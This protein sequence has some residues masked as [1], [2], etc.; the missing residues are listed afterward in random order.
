MKHKFIF[1]FI[2][3]LLFPVIVLG[4]PADP[5]DTK[6]VINGGK[7]I[8][9]RL[10]GDEFAHGHETIDGYTVVY[11]KH[12][13]LWCYA[14]LDDTGR[15]VPTDLI[16]GKDDPISNN[17]K[18]HLRFS[19]EFIKRIRTEMSHD[20]NRYNKKRNNAVEGKYNELAIFIDFPDQPHT[21]DTTDFKEMLF[22]ESTDDP[23]SFSDYYKE[24][25]NGK[26][27][28]KGDVTGWYTAKNN[29]AYYGEDEN[30][31]IDIYLTEL[32]REALKLAD[33]DIDFSKYDNNKS[34]YISVNIFHS[35]PGE[36][37][38]GTSEDE[39][40]SQSRGISPITLDGVEIDSFTIQPEIDHEVMSS[41]GVFCH[42]Y[43]HQLGLPDLYDYDYSSYG[44]GAFCLMAYGADNSFFGKRLDCPAHPCA[45]A[46]YQLG[47]IDLIDMTSSGNYSLEPV[48]QSQKSLIIK[49]SLPSNEFFLVENRQKIGFDRGLPG[50]EGG[51]LIWHVD[52]YEYDNDIDNFRLV[53][54]EQAQ[55]IQ[56]MDFPRSDVRASMGSDDDYFREGKE[57]RSDTSPDSKS[58][59]N[60][61]SGVSIIN[62]KKENST[63]NY[64]VYAT[65]RNFEIINKWSYETPDHLY[66]SPRIGPDGTI[67]FND[68]DFLYVLSPDGKLKGKFNEWPNFTFGPDGSVYI[69]A[70]DGFVYAYN[71]NGTLKWSVNTHGRV[72]TTIIGPDGSI[73]LNTK[74]IL[75]AIN[76]DGGIKW[77][78]DHSYAAFSQIVIGKQGTIYCKVGTAFI[79][80]F[81]SL[82]G[83]MKWNKA[84]EGTNL[85]LADKTGDDDILYLGNDTGLFFA[86]QPDGTLK[87]QMRL[88]DSIETN[89]VVGDDG[90]IYFVIKRWGIYAFNSTSSLKW[91]FTF[92]QMWHFPS[93]PV[94]GPDGNIYVSKSSGHIFVFN[95]DGTWKI[96]YG[97]IGDILTSPAIAPDMTIYA[98]C[99][100]GSLYAMKENDKIELV[101]NKI[102]DKYIFNN[103][104][105]LKL[106]LDLYTPDK[107]YTADFYFILQNNNSDEVLYAMNWET[108]PSPMLKGIPFGKNLS[109]Y[110]LPLINITIPNNNP[111]IVIPGDYTFAIVAIDPITG[112]LVSNVSMTQFET[113]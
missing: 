65:Q 78:T 95:P 105:D 58:S 76:D 34:G 10:F 7:E 13:A 25:S 63:L 4:I 11:D 48:E 41:I 73:F 97:K 53:D 46:K 44:V 85:L 17:I 5:N 62:F 50:N 111:P 39:I 56:T 107:A 9:I 54:L 106:T 77:T 30:G 102:P 2:S 88:D 26:L 80:A 12:K 32:I 23:R 79:Y 72:A 98:A 66:D 86:L 60:V 1:I 31:N 109:L 35:G 75:F 113:K 112:K 52:E 84:F 19:K 94:I 101:L 64:S 103:G 43:G 55:A 20:L 29:K 71:K 81:S 3:I 82:D 59:Y 83:S 38:N 40:W 14:K 28:I 61:P 49:G 45:W 33:A 18:K 74:D 21:Y 6:T 70:D 93:S 8:S 108:I 69:G 87:W 51:I 37:E 99:W 16:A 68:K 96:S 24:V 47:W 67:Y 92:N 90:T 110:D 91:A 100:D 104:D 36:E 89:P 57:F 27:Q 22:S 42:E 15:L